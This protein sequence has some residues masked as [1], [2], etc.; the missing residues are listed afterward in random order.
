MT[1]T[2]SDGTTSYIPLLA[3]GWESSREAQN[4]LHPIVG[5]ASVEVTL[6]PAG[7]RTGT[8]ELLTET[9]DDALNIEALAAQAKVLTLTHDDL[10]SLAMSFVASG[11]ITVTLDEDSQIYWTVSID[12]TEVDT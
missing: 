10:L 2:I 1:T 5:S 3:L 4:V 8:L 11:D 6:R 9:L 12:Y 7:L